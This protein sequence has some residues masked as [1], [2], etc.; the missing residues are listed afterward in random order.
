M[1]RNRM[2]PL[3]L[4]LLAILTRM[5]SGDRVSVPFLEREAKSLTN[6]FP[7]KQQEEDIDLGID[8]DS[9]QKK[10]S[11]QSIPFSEVA[12]SYAGGGGKRCGFSGGGEGERE[13]KESKRC[14]DKV[15]TE[16]VTEYDTVYTC[17]HSYNRR[18]AKTLTTTYNPTQEEECEENFVKKCFIEYSKQA[19]DV[20]V[21]VCR[22]PL[23]KNKCEKL[24][25]EICSTEFESEC[26]TEQHEHQVEDDVPECKTVEDTKC[27]EI[28]SGYSS[29]QQC[30]K[31]PREECFLT[32]QNRK[33]YSPQTRCEKKPV[34]FCGP[35]GCGFVEGD[36]VCHKRTQTI[37]GD[38]P[39]E[40]CSLEPQSKCRF[41]TKL[42]PQLKE[43]EKC[44]DVPKEVCGRAQVNPRKVSKQVIKKWCYVPDREQS[45]HSLFNKPRQEDKDLQKVAEILLNGTIDIRNEC[46]WGNDRKP[47]CLNTDRY[48]T[49]D[50]SC[51]N[52][53]QPLY[54]QAGTSFQRILEA[55]YDEKYLPRLA[56]SGKQL[57]SAREIS[58]EAFVV[59][60]PSDTNDISVYFMQFGQFID[61]DLTHSPAAGIECECCLKDRKTGN[62]K[63]IYPDDPYNNHP[64]QCFP[65]EIPRNDKY[66]G[67]KG[68]RCMEFTRSELSPPLTCVAGKK[69]QRNAITH[70]LDGGNIY[71][72][73]KEE[74]LNLRDGND[75]SRLKTDKSVGRELLPSCPRERRARD[76]IEACVGC[77]KQCMFSGDFRV[78]EQPGLTV[79][80]TVWMREHNR[81]AG[82]LKNMNSQWDDEKVFQEARRIVIAE[83]QHVVYN[84]WLP[85]VL[86]KEYM[87]TENLLPQKSGHSRDYDENL[88]PRI[89][90]EFAAAAFRFGHSMIPTHIP[91]HDSRERNISHLNLKN[92]FFDPSSLKKDTEFIDD[93]IRG[94]T[95]EKAPA[96]DPVFVD[97]IVNHLFA[98]GLD[99][100]ALNIQRGRDHGIP[101][102]NSY[103]KYCA[104]RSNN[105]NAAANFDQ[106][107]SGGYLD[108]NDVRKLSGLYNNVVDD[109]D[110]FVGGTLEDHT[111]DSIL[112]PTFQCIIG[113]QFKLLKKGDRFWYENGEFSES[114]FSQTQ[115]NEI[116]KTSIARILCDNTDIVRIQ[117]NV[118]KVVNNRD[119]RFTQCTGD[120]IPGINL[121][122]F[123]E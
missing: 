123:K 102:Y 20:T 69:E 30:T 55:T 87:T 117:P 57:P 10:G 3:C 6:A 92:K 44:F 68:R 79:E 35:A 95:Q 21:T 94:Y 91:S 100:P 16:E 105:L 113:E 116:R 72:N 98:A 26:I 81:L 62:E 31:W 59:G 99:L 13:V 63:W 119:N 60:S 75:R 27:E 120:F 23:V 74:E 97:D 56:E 52:K 29:S 19:Q 32:K 9:R 84:E 4:V 88:D 122:F 104:S 67:S 77:T 85:I 70:W 106:L 108:R 61:H 83:W 25:E 115:L 2:I 73:T 109:V 89:Y 48:R 53:Q 8:R 43:V 107:T 78:N 66:W 7:F 71:G 49:V 36:E 86:G 111:G 47:K 39:E 12:S 93:T 58:Q 121:D 22:T 65:I 101:G 1:V 96:W 45:G 103:R 114:R 51:N 34:N 24:G 118:F 14:I 33:K 17:Q 5:I 50:G 38:K 112:G 82:Q 40:T 46:P 90:N 76:K 28:P 64:H 42:V 80:H 54:G 11:T 110:L 37:V 15:F 18:C 41:V